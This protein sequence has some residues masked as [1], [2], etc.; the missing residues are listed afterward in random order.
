MSRPGTR[1]PPASGPK[2]QAATCNDARP[3]RTAFS[4]APVQT[5]KCCVYTPH[6]PQN[7][8]F[9]AA[10]SDRQML[11]THP[12]S[13]K[14]PFSGPPAQTTTRSHRQG[15]GGLNSWPRNA[16]AG[17]DLLLRNREGQRTDDGGQTTEN[18]RRPAA[19]LSAIRDP[20]SKNWV[21]FAQSAVDWNGEII[22]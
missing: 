4:G 11:H 18:G 16:T 5:A 1:Q 20:Q 17:I 7:R 3:P 21:R 12:R 15:V 2:I 22:G 14:T 13:P 10:S 19:R 6:G 8:V 9:R